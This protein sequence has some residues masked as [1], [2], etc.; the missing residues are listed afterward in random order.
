MDV[1]NSPIPP[2]GPFRSVDFSVLREVVNHVLESKSPL[3]QDSI[4]EAPDFTEKIRFNGLTQGIANLLTV[5]SYQTEAVRDFFS[6]NSTFAR[7]Q[8][9]DH[10]AAEYT[11]VCKRITGLD[12]KPIEIGDMVFFDLLARLI[13]EPRDARPSHAAIAQ[14]AALVVMS[15]YFEACDI[16][17]EP[18]AFT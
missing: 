6:R 2:V 12:I 10:L 4:L 3:T 9:R 8:L 1:L 18:D 17:E 11:K 5:A 13:P 7:Q 14:E 16:F 15:F